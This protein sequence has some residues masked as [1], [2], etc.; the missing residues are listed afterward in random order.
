MVHEPVLR[1]RCLDIS[2]GRLADRTDF[3]LLAIHPRESSGAYPAF[4]IFGT[5]AELHIL[6]AG[7]IQSPQIPGHG[8]LH[9]VADVVYVKRI[10]VSP[11]M[12]GAD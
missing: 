2:D 7:V 3:H 10:T 11:T 6:I 12:K 1:R 4:P 9:R 5:P 8:A